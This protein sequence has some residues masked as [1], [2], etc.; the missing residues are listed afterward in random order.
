M[1]LS[2]IYSIKDFSVSSLPDQ[3]ATQR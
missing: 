3:S 1:L 2:G